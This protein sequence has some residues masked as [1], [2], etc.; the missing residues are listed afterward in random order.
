MLCFPYSNL[1]VQ[2]QGCTDWYWL[3]ADIWVRDSSKTLYHIGLWKNIEM[4]IDINETLLLKILESNQGNTFCNEFTWFRAQFNERYCY[5]QWE[6]SIQDSWRSASISF[7]III[8]RQRQM[9]SD[10]TH[11]SG[12]WQQIINS[13]DNHLFHLVL[14][15]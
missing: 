2:N 4:L 6:I 8:Y 11:F 9:Y 13:K 3:P 5:V 12:C 1:E 14:V 7:F 15:W 10:A